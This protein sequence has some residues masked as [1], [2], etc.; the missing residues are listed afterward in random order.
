[1]PLD[2]Q[3]TSCFLVA[4]SLLNN[5]FY[6]LQYNVQ[7]L[8]TLSIHLVMKTL[9]KNTHELHLH[10]VVPFVSNINYNTLMEQY[11]G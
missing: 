6:R 11:Y 4:F 9:N 10:D 3:R 7:H 1:M 2:R 8:P 5:V